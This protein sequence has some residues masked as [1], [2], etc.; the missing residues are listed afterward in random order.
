MVDRLQL[1]SRAQRQGEDWPAASKTK[2]QPCFACLA[3]FYIQGK[4]I[5][6]PS[7]FVEFKESNARHSSF[8]ALYFTLRQ[9]DLLNKLSLQTNSISLSLFFY[10]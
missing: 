9:I 1:L 5:S 2:L 10:C 3:Q 4:H 6:C 7:F 8:F